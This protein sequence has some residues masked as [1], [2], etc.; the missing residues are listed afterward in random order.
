[1]LMILAALL[2]HFEHISPS[3]PSLKTLIAVP[4]FL[5][6]SRVQHDCHVYLSNLKKYTL[7]EHPLF[8]LILCPHYT[9]EC[10][11]YL[12][13]AILAAPEGQLLNTTMLTTLLFTATNL[14]ITA[15]STR[16]WYS[17]KFG[18][19]MIKDR[20]RMIPFLY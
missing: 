10:V 13:L 14:A 20:W 3:R 4:L 12:S 6:A 9:S 8:R 19:D 17:D 1:M 11:I 15:E 5:F 18:A 16:R 7:P 2:N